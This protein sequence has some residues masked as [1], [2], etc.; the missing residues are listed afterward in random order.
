MLNEYPQEFVDS[1]MNPL[2]SNRPYSDII[3]QVT[4][5]IPYVKGSPRNSDALETVSMSGPVS[6]LNIRS[7]GH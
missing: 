3:Y 4:A 2:R 6:K 7:M 1:I 5:I